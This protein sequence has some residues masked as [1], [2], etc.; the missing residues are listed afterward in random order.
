MY[1]SVTVYGP[2]AVCRTTN[3]F[4]HIGIESFLS[5]YLSDKMRKNEF[6]PWSN[7]RCAA[8]L[9]LYTGRSSLSQNLTRIFHHF[10]S[11]QIKTKITNC[12]QRCFFGRL[13]TFWNT[14][15]SPVFQK[16]YNIQ[17]FMCKVNT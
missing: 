15:P 2:I 13:S 17:L 9:F 8:I 10:C 6:T 5:V 4:L 7:T 3:E 11:I 12:V 1:G 14:L 16:T